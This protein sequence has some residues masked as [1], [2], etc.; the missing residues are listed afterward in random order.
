MWPSRDSD[1]QTFPCPPCS[2]PSGQWDCVSSQPTFVPKDSGMS[3]SVLPLDTEGH[4]FELL[5]VCQLHSNLTEEGE[6]GT[7]PA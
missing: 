5:P 4:A 1:I 6:E 7:T 3:G 2:G